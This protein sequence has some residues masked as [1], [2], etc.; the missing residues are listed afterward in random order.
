MR[1]LNVML[2]RALGESLGLS[3]LADALA[4]SPG[5]LDPLPPILPGLLYLLGPQVAAFGVQLIGQVAVF[6]RCQPCDHAERH[7]ANTLLGGDQE[8]VGPVNHLVLIIDQY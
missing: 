2:Y 6:V 7:A 3:N 4:L 5:G 1:R 8:T